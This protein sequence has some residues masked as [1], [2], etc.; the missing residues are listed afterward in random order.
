MVIE[1]ISSRRERKSINAQCNTFF[2]FS[3]LEKEIISDNMKWG[4]PG[5]DR[6]YVMMTSEDRNGIDVLTISISS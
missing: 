4:S 5:L 1:P 2:F 6:Y 3:F